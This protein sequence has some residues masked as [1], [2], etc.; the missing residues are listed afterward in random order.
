MLCIAKNVWG[1]RINM[2][3]IVKVF[4]HAKAWPALWLSNWKAQPAPAA[5]TSGL[6]CWLCCCRGPSLPLGLEQV[7][8]LRSQSLR[9]SSCILPPA[10][11]QT[12]ALQTRQVSDADP[13]VILAKRRL[14]MSLAYFSKRG[15]EHRMEVHQFC[16]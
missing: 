3:A 15:A 13:L 6:K 4:Q 10:G 14:I 11:W 8:C 5:G 2:P 7:G 9:M 1:G 12:M 16:A